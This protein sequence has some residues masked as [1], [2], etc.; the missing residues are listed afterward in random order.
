MDEDSRAFL[1]DLLAL[2]G[3]QECWAV[4]QW[5]VLEAD[6]DGALTE[7]SV[8]LPGKQLEG[9][10]PLPPSVGKCTRLRH[11]CLRGVGLGG[12]CEELGRCVELRSLSFPRNPLRGDVPES[13]NN[14]ALLEKLHI[15]DCHMTGKFLAMELFKRLGSSEGTVI[16]LGNNHFAGIDFRDH[17]LNQYTTGAL[18]PWMPDLDGKTPR[19]SVGVASFPG[20]EFMQWMLMLMRSESRSDPGAASELCVFLEDYASAQAKEEAID[21]WHAG[22]FWD[23]PECRLHARYFEAASE[24]SGGQTVLAHR[25]FGCMWFHQWAINQVRAVKEGYKRFMVF[26]LCP[27]VA[28]SVPPV[29]PIGTSQKAEY[30]F[31]KSM[32]TAYPDI[33]IGVADVSNLEYFLLEPLN[34]WNSWFQFAPI[35]APEGR[36]VVLAALLLVCR[37]GK[38]WSEDPA[39]CPRNAVARFL[40]TCYLGLRREQIIRFSGLAMTAGIAASGVYWFYTFLLLDVLFMSEK[41]QTVVKAV[42]HPLG[43]LLVTMTAGMILAYEFSVI[44]FFFFR[45]S[46][47][48][49]CQNLVDCTVTT[50]YLGFRRDLGRDI[51][52][53]TVQ[54]DHWYG[55]VIFDLSFFL[56][57]TTVLMNILF[58]IIVDT[59]AALRNQVKRRE[60]YKRSTTFIA[61]IERSWI[62]KAA[63]AEG[64]SSGFDYLEGERQHCWNYMNFIFYLRHKDKLNYMGPETRISHLIARD[65]ISW[66][67]LY[68]CSLLQR[69]ADR[70]NEC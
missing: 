21:E 68:D 65:D 16:Y 50:L 10:P 40:V 11:L 4:K 17:G 58:G 35:Q 20:R 9:E 54:S 15:D 28:T 62:D 48:S 63:L 47:G 60:R 56:L 59:F 18:R 30:A 7:L 12:L 8:D 34:C 6:E 29:G 33:T 32:Q 69:Q 31:L 25:K 22:G 53:V 42:V 39:G 27:D 36:T 70:L 19:G 61:S 26:T 13:L 38:T 46:Y 57:I 66:V 49:S 5:M 24:C 1:E 64:I 43:S 2:P 67:P 55:R 45:R 44:A 14:L 52:P 3:F 37:C 41:L 51:E 23:S